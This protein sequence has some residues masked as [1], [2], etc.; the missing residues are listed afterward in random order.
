MARA[1]TH[2]VRHPDGSLTITMKRACNG[3]DALIGDATEAEIDAAVASLPLPDVT[4]ECP[5]CTTAAST[6]LEG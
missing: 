5:A 4:G 3:C 2:D 1:Y 6:A